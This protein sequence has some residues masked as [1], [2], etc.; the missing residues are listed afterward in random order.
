M[1]F[2]GKVMCGK[3]DE[4]LCSFVGD[5]IISFLSFH[6][7]FFVVI[8]ISFSFTDDEGDGLGC[9]LRDDL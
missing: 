7:F 5:I 9:M 2:K 8:I 1:N 6:L 4:L 3:I